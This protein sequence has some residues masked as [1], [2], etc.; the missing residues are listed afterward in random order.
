M[1]TQ[2]DKQL[3]KVNSGM[4]QAILANVVESCQ[5]QPAQLVDISIIIIIGEPARIARAAVSI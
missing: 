2:Q 3:I 1:Y 4:S 5:Y